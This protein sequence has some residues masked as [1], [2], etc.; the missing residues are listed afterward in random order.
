MRVGTLAVPG[1]A[2]AAAETPAATLEQLLKADTPSPDRFAASFLVAVPAAEVR[3]LIDGM[4]QAYGTLRAIEPK[5]DGFLVRLEKATVPTSITLDGEGRITGLW[6]G[7]PEIAGE[8]TDHAAA[9]RALPGKTSLLVLTDGE[10][11]V[12]DAADVPLAVGS[13]AKLA[14]LAALDDAVTAGRLAWDQVVPLDPKWISLPTGQLQG[15][16]EGTPV[17]IATLANLMISISDNTATDALITLVGREAIEALT[18]ANTPFPTTREFFTLKTDANATLRTAWKTADA[19][20][21]REILKQ[22]ADAPLPTSVGS[23]ATHE[24]E[25]FMTAREICALLDR[26]AALPALSINPGV[27]EAARWQ[28]VAFKGGSEIGVLNLSTRVI[29]RD[30]RVRCIVASWNHDAALDDEKLIAPYRAIIARLAASEK[31]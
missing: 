8:I 28:E 18:P 21:R 11:V 27:A 26:T 31:D 3:R 22:I 7:T 16:P 4:R 30:G 9:I 15:W 14:I 29:G 5:G 23:G 6:F 25:W 13:A 1:A 2:I 24:V 10:T 17:T 12:A 20:G 19:S